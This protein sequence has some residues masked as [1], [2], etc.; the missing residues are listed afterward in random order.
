MSK[1]SYIS[2]LLPFNAVYICSSLL[3]FGMFETV[4]AGLIDAFPN[5]LRKRRVLLTFGLAAVSYC[6]SLPI[7][8]EVRNLS[9]ST[10][11]LIGAGI[12][13][14]ISVCVTESHLSFLDYIVFASVCLSFSM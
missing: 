3:Q 13:L 10:C 2:V 4:V 1:D 11:Y 5:Q 9:L 8:T 7:A 14:C 12:C 6:I